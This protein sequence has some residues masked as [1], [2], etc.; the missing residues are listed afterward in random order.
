MIRLFFCILFFSSSLSILFAQDDKPSEYIRGD[1][2]KDGKVDVLDLTYLIDVVN[3]NKED[4]N[5][6]GSSTERYLID[7]L[8]IYGET[9][10]KTRVVFNNKASLDYEVSC[11]AAVFGEMAAIPVFYSLNSDDIRYSINE[12]PFITGCVN[13]GVKFYESGTYTINVKRAKTP[14]LLYDRTNDV[15]CDITREPY[16]FTTS[17][18]VFNSR[19]ALIS[20]HCNLD[21]NYDGC[22]DIGDVHFLANLLLLQK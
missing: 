7:L 15:L 16:I 6:M 5:I 9:E 10:C 21:I 1:V 3:G 20:E 11:D 4:T 12:R 19:F 2:N 13:L 22:I 14:V 17:A 18:G 8:L